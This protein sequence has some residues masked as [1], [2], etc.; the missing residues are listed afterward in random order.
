[1]YYQI[2]AYLFYFVTSILFIV[3]RLP[4]FS[5]IVLYAYLDVYLDAI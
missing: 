5:C 1:M 2:N 4:Y 3:S